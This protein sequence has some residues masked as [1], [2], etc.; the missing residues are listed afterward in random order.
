MNSTARLILP[1]VFFLAGWYLPWQVLVG[2][3]LLT[4]WQMNAMGREYLKEQ[5]K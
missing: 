5:G 4:L 1:N 3:L 2:M